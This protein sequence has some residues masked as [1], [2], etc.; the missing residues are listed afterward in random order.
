MKTHNTGKIF[1][2]IAMILSTAIIS[3]KKDN[4]G[5]PADTNPPKTSNDISIQ[6]MNFSPA[7]LTVPAGSTVTWTNND[8]FA[9]TVTSKT[10]AFDSGSIANGKTFSFTFSTAGKYDY[11][12]SI[13]TSMTGLVVV[14]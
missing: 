14:Q 12:C 10:N 4:T 8:G 2:V 1:I 11:Y 7:S 3:C 9:H 5:T 6:N 13:H